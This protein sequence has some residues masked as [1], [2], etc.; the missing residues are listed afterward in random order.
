MKYFMFLSYEKFI[1]DPFQPVELETIDLESE[2]QDQNP[3]LFPD[4]L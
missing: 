1:L 3:Y 4:K 2:M